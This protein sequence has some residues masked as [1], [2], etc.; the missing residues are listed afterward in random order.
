MKHY[1]LALLL[2][3]GVCVLSAQNSV[4]DI[5]FEWEV[6]VQTEGEET[7]QESILLFGLSI[8]RRF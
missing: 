4:L 6:N 3:L 8:G 1:F 7:G 2:C 5:D